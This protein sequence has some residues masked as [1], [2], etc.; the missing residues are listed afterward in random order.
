VFELDEA[1]LV[2]AIRPTQTQRAA[3]LRFDVRFAAQPAARFAEE[4]IKNSR[5]R[6]ANA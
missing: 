5:G 3:D 2:A 4:G 6:G 1:T